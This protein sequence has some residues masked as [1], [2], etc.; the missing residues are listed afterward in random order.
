MLRSRLPLLGLRAFEATARHLSVRKAAIELCVTP[1]AVSQQV[2]LL[3]ETVGVPLIQRKGRSIALTDA[4]QVLHPSLTQA[5][6]TMEL[7][8]NAVSRRSWH[9]ALKICLLPTL[10][11]RWLM[12]RLARFHGAH[13]ELD[14]QIM[15]S[16]R[17]IQFDEDD[18]D[19]ACFTGE[20][21]PAGLDGVRLFDDEFIP[22]CRP[23]L[24]KGPL[25]R[26]RPLDLLNET[27]LYSVRRMDDWQRW[28]EH[29]GEQNVQVSRRLSFG[30]ASLAIQAA[31]DG[32]GVAIVQRA[33][34]ADFLKQGLLITPIDITGRTPMGYYLVWSV[35]RGTTRA[36]QSFHQWVLEE[37][38]SDGEALKRQ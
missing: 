24:F 16:F 2:K 17:P 33:Y 19:M 14:I 22:V 18:V 5:F 27:L 13:P 6:Q 34:V 9:N 28:F 7:T 15:T 26:L 35:R 30:N 4:G 25:D 21:L 8:V 38:R 12:P 10:T 31:V 1:G 36:F 20:S 32:L 29:A 37:V 3:E 23:D 11:E